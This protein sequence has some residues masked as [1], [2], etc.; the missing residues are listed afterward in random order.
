MVRSIVIALAVPGLALAGGAVG[1]AQPHAAADYPVRPVRFIVPFNAGGAND[2][3]ARVIAQKLTDRW[4]RQF[5]PDN[6][7]GAAGSLGVDTAAR[8]APDGYTIAIIS[9]SLAVNSA[10]SPKLPYDLTKDLQAIAQ[11]SSLFYVV[12]LHPSVPATSI[13]E[14]I[15]YARANPGK[16]DYGS[17]GTFGLQHLSGE[18]FQHLTG[19]K[20]VHVPYKGGAQAL[21]DI[22]SGQIR[23]GFSTL[24]SARGHISAGR[25][26][27]LAITTRKRSPA[28]PEVPTLDESGVRGYEV[29]QWFGIVAPAQT[30]R[31]IVAKLATAISE[32]VHAPDVAQRFSADGSTPVSSGPDAFAAHV[33]D[34]IAKWRRLAKETGLKME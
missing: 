13:K 15:A 11:V 17:S 32:S 6:R 16:I 27:A 3:T 19:T 24:L 8:A 31:P 26:R 29:D 4:G 25:V 5:V 12:T 28:L 30:P 22:V 33:R 14:L 23:M 9:A 20:L 7:P 18:L 2:L 10:V 1:A 21:A 34:E